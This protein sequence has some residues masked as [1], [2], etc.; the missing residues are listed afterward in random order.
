MG[1]TVLHAKSVP[2]HLAR[3]DL[4]DQILQSGRDVPCSRREETVTSA[5]SSS[6]SPVRF[7]VANSFSATIGHAAHSDEPHSIFFYSGVEHE[8]YWPSPTTPYLG[9]HSYDHFFADV[10][11]ASCIG[12][13]K[14]GDPDSIL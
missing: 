10:I 9:C 5:P 11:I 12:E 4:R 8:P 13:S 6:H 2:K 14:G 3:R 1:H 7:G